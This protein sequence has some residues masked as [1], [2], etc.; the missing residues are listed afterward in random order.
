MWCD[1]ASKRSASTRKKRPELFRSPAV[2]LSSKFD[3]GLKAD[4]NSSIGISKTVS[5]LRLSAPEA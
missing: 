3:A 1:S 4:S 2:F 5:S